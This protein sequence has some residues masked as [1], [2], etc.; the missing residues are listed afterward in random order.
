MGWKSAG[1]LALLLLTAAAAPPGP[2]GPGTTSEPGE[3]AGGT[4]S[5]AGPGAPSFS[6]A[7]DT[8]E[9]LR[10]LPPHDLTARPDTTS[11]EVVHGLPAPEALRPIDQPRR[12]PIYR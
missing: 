5:N 8:C 9:D 11:G 7:D 10:V 4:L 3:Q 1:S 12:P 6:A 2:C